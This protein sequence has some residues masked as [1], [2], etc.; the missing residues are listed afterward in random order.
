MFIERKPV[1]GRSTTGPPR[2]DAGCCVPHRIPSGVAA[3]RADAQLILLCAGRIDDE[4]RAAQV[5][6]KAVDDELEEI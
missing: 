5:V 2:N 1:P 6:V 3:R 4:E